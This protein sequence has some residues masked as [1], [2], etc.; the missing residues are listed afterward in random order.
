[1]AK[2]DAR[3]NALAPSTRERILES[4]LDIVVNEGVGGL[5]IRELA[6]A[7]G[8]REGSIYNHF[9]GRETILR[10]LFQGLDARLSPLGF[11]FDLGAASDEVRLAVATELRSR[12]FTA[13]LLDA[14]DHLV[15]GLSKNHAA[16]QLIR[17]VLSA[18]FHDEAARRA[19]EEVF[20]KDISRVFGSICQIA[21]DLGLFKPNISPQSVTQL[22]AAAIEQ[23]LIRSYGDV[24]LD[25][26]D[27]ILSPLLETIGALSDTPAPPGS[28][29]VP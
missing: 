8:I 5:R 7:V 28:A 29:I 4:A 12:G 18:R 2:P 25:R 11:V 26:F 20:A 3:P 13:F 1:M 22:I 17:A 6:R 9:E 21:S 27:A 16:L 15:S 10:E 24:K 23:S 14:K 19:Y